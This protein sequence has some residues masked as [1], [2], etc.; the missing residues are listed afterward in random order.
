MAYKVIEKRVYF[1]I[2]YNTIMEELP[3]LQIADVKSI[4]RRMKKYVDMEILFSH[5]SKGR[6]SYYHDGQLKYR[7][8]TF[9][10]YCFNPQILSK[11]LSGGTYREKEYLQKY[12]KATEDVNAPCIQRESTPRDAGRQSTT[13]KAGRQRPA[14]DYSTINPSTID[15]EV[16]FDGLKYIITS[17][18]WIRHDWNGNVYQVHNEPN[19][20]VKAYAIKYFGVND[21]F[22]KNKLQGDL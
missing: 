4:S 12:E 6:E 2:L 21:T 13:N 18:G 3:I 9:T 15:S 16:I 14:K 10:Y 7:Y 8:G 22:L 5:I 17:D 1:W 11:L 20:Q 19:E